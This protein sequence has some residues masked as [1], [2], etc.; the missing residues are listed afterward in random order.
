MKKTR[1][2]TA[3]GA[4]GVAAALAAPASAAE[5]G[6]YIVSLEDGAAMDPTSH[7]AEDIRPYTIID[8]YY[9]ELSP[10]EAARLADDPRVAAVEP[11]RPI[12][13]EGSGS[14]PSPPWNLDRVDQRGPI[15]DDEYV[16]D[17]D[18]EGVDA[19]VLDTGVNAVHPTFGGRVAPGAD[20]IGDGDGTEDCNGHGT[21]VAG[22]IAGEEFGVAKAATIVPVRALDC[23][24]AGTLAGVIAAVEWITENADGP[25]VANLS[26][27]GPA[28][29]TALTEAVQNSIASGVSYTVAAGGSNADACGYTPANIPEAIT[30]SGTDTA[31]RRASFANWGDCVDLFAPAVGITVPWG[32]GVNTVS[33]T[34]FAAPHAAGAVAIYLSCHP[35]KTAGEVHDWIV[36]NATA[37]AVQ[38]PQGPDRFLYTRVDTC[39]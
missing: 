3:L 19:Y 30:V 20:F 25:S 33:G 2:F 34:S 1:L 39:A 9:A 35:E 36:D 37:G 7:G 21:A 11:D 32:D 6:G 24:G 12:M 23:N 4:L 10:A 26:L 8:G 38:N 14:Q 28:G 18:G 5:S 27:G 29:H 15:L 13:L 31:D 16:W 22:V 17:G